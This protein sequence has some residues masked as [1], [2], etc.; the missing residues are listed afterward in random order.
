M[1]DP[2]S[3]PEIARELGVSQRQ[4]ERQFKRHVGCTVVQFGLLLRLQN[5]RV[6]L[7]STSHE[8]CRTNYYQVQDAH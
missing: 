2:L 6:L 1:E 5:A 8:Q 4:L 3:V 7:I